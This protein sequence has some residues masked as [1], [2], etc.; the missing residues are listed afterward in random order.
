MEIGITEILI[1]LMIVY[2]VVA[3]EKIVDKKRNHADNIINPKKQDNRNYYIHNENEKDP[4]KILEL[5]N[6][7]TKKEITLAYRNMVKKYHPDLIAGLAPEYH[8]IAESKMKM[9]NSAY[10]KLLKVSNNK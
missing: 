9:I 3:I 2:Y 4:Y 7:A 5:D 1:I 10:Q 8:E 6:N